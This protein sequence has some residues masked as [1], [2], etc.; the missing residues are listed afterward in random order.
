MSRCCASNPQHRLVKDDVRRP[1]RQRQDYPQYAR[2]ARRERLHLLVQRQAELLSQLQRELRVKARYEVRRHAY[3][4]L[5][6][7]AVREQVLLRHHVHLAQRPVAARRPLAVYQ[8]LAA[9]RVQPV[10][11]YVQHRRLARAVAPQQAVYLPAA[12]AHTDVRER[13]DAAETLGYIF[14]LN[15]HRYILFPS[16][17][18]ALPARGPA[19]WPP[20]P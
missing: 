10:R 16:F 8:H 4:R 18:A 14:Q 19:L 6:L 13:L 2:V 5:H 11:D 17:F 15:R 1:R 20:S 9:V 3:R 7:H 12:E